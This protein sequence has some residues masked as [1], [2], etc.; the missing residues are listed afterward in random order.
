M[1]NNWI[2]AVGTFLLV[3]SLVWL[4]TGASTVPGDSSLPQEPALPDFVSRKELSDAMKDVVDQESL[5]EELKQYVG[6]KVFEDA[7]E[8]LEARIRQLETVSSLNSSE[9]LSQ[10]AKLD[11]LGTEVLNHG[12]IIDKL[13]ADL[14]DALT[15]SEQHQRILDAISQVDG[16]RFLPDILGNMDTP[17]LRADMDQVVREVFAQNSCTLVIWNKTQQTQGIRVNEKP[18]QT[19]V[20]NDQLVVKEL[21]VGNV[22]TRLD[23]QRIVN[24]A[25]GPPNYHQVI[26]IVESSVT[27]YQDP[28]YGCSPYVYAVP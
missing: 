19:I 4:M 12:R 26:H 17:K 1:Q 20:P 16:G 7:K 15:F 5:A 21:P 6:K 22:S 10:G 24:W 13:S 8:Q 18:R 28:E 3:V 14:A 2:V 23:G 9:L 27:A 25:V 11:I